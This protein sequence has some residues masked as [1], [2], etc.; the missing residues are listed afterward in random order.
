[1]LDIGLHHALVESIF[2]YDSQVLGI[3]KAQRHHMLVFYLD[4]ILTKQILSSQPTIIVGHHFF[5]QSLQVLVHLK[6]DAL[7]LIL[8][9]TL[10][11]D[12]RRNLRARHN[13]LR[14]VFHLVNLN[15]Y[16]L[17]VFHIYLS[18]HLP[19]G[20]GQSILGIAIARLQTIALIIT[21]YQ[22]L[23]IA[24]FLIGLH[25]GNET[26]GKG[27]YLLFC[28]NLNHAISPL[29]TIDSSG[30]STFQHVNGFDGLSF[31]MEYLREIFIRG[32]HHDFIIKFYMKYLTIHHNKGRVIT[33]RRHY[34]SSTKA[35]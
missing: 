15:H 19:M 9:C 29:S 26:V 27:L 20:Y 32:M 28:G 4:A 35:H 24:L 11:L 13:I 31:Q 25:L 1:M 12:D 10:L 21:T 23:W 30:C 2:H 33:I 6:R 8:L 22:N 7:R 3:S 17:E 34:P 16:A 18:S 5:L 14:V